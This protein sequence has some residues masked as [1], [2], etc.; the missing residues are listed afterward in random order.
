MW[1]P[2]SADESACVILSMSRT[3]SESGEEIVRRQEP[4][5]PFAAFSSRSSILSGVTSATC[6][7]MP[8]YSAIY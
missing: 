6:T 5:F 1:E 8:V 3:G 2:R 4:A 7:K